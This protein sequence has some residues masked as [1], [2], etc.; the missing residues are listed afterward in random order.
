MKRNGRI[1]LTIAKNGTVSKPVVVSRS[2]N[3]AVDDAVASLLTKLNVVP[4]PPQ[5]CTIRITL[6]IR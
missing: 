4:V 1:E 2:G 5:A 6:D 3:K